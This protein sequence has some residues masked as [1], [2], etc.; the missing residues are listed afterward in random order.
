MQNRRS[1]GPYESGDLAM[2]SE[3]TYRTPFKDSPVQGKPGAVGARTTRPGVMLTGPNFPVLDR[4]VLFGML[5]VAFF[6]PQVRWTD[7]FRTGAQVVVDSQQGSLLQQL[8]YGVCLVLAAILTWRHQA[9]VWRAV[10]DGGW[11]VPLFILLCAAS[12]FWSAYPVITVKRVIQL[13]LLWLMG[14]LGASYFL[15]TP[16]LARILRTSFAV[17]IILSFLMAVLLPQYGRDFHVHGGAWHGIVWQKNSLGAAAVVMVTVWFDA[18]CNNH[19]RSM[20]AWAM[21]LLGLFVLLMAKSSTA[22][23]SVIIA[24]AVYSAVLFLQIFR[25]KST[26]LGLIGLGVVVVLGLHGYMTITGEVPSWSDLISPVTS[27]VG[28]GAD[29]TG[30]TDIWLNLMLSI[31]KHPWLGTGYGAF[32]IGE[33][34][35]AQY[36]ADYMNWMPPY[37]HNGFLDIANELGV[38]GLLLVVWACLGHCYKVVRL[39]QYDSREAALHMA[40]FVVLFISNFSESYLFY[41]VAFQNVLF[42]CSIVTVSNSLRHYRRLKLMS[43]EK[44]HGGVTG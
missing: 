7:M 9:Q 17:L 25:K 14:I 8:V 34:G 11:V 13:A 19:R 21:L 40:L 41:G 18:V 6:Y 5:F 3:M 35:P 38:V 4:R 43:L 26:L 23:I 24:I 15:G 42:I 37:G 39:S 36:I 32:W 31:Q 10:R 28:K 33:G 44:W 27:S 22:L 29:L 30:R 2:K 12:I 20:F 16:F 1:A